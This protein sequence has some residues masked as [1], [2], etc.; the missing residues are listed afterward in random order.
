LLEKQRAEAR[1]RREAKFA[2]QAVADVIAA[3]EAEGM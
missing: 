3:A 1:A 2:Q